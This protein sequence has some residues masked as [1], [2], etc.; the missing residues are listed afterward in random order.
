VLVSPMLPD[1]GD[2][3]VADVDHQR[4]VV[5]QHVRGRY[6]GPCIGPRAVYRTTPHNRVSAVLV[7]VV[8]RVLVVVWALTGLPGWLSTAW[9]AVV[10]TA[11]GS[12]A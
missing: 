2:I 7:V 1:L 12:G 9:L 8:R 3:A 5:H 11:A 6:G 10:P 4:V